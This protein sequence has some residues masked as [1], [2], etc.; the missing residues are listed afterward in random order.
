M[1][2]PRRLLRRP[3]AGELG[4]RDRRLPAQRRRRPPASTPT[5]RSPTPGPT[6]PP[7]SS[8]RPTARRRRAGS[9]RRRRSSSPARTGKAQVVVGHDDASPD[10]RDQGRPMRWTTE[11]SS[12]APPRHPP[13]HRR[14]RG[15]RARGP[16][17]ARRRVLRRATAAV[18]LAGLGIA[19]YL[20]SCTT[21]APRRVR[22]RPRL[23]GRAELR[24]REARR[25]PGR[26]AR[27]ARLRGDPRLA[28]ARR[29]DGPHRHRAP[30]ARR[31]RL[32]AWLTYVEVARLDAICIW[33]VGS[34]VC[35]V[36]LA[37]LERARAC[38]A[39]PAPRPT[40]PRA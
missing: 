6:R 19:A 10:R 7:T 8:T 40:G 33:C 15:G 37:G 28:R 1:A 3:G 17:R 9:T 5:R 13:R 30:R 27:P 31:R 34:A 4:L 29:R 36:L 24:L 20:T 39:Q 11:P 38:S 22:D 21:R 16:A 32:L 18:A 14:R 23:R 25:H 2:L 12:G 35:M 26:P